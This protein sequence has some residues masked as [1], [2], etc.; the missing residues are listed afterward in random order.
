[1]R[2]RNTKLLIW[3]NLLHVGLISALTPFLRNLVAYLSSLSRWKY[4][5]SHNRRDPLTENG[6]YA[7][8][9]LAE[10][11]WTSYVGRVYL[12]IVRVQRLVPTSV[13]DLESPIRTLSKLIRRK[14]DRSQTNT[15]LGSQSEYFTVLRSIFN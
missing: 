10:K 5:L 4:L 7:F 15:P 9:F 11:E 13:C 12:L 6:I 14:F 1:M 3:L 2:E 8:R